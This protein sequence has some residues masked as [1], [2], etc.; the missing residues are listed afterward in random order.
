MRLFVQFFYGEVKK[1]F[2]GLATG[3][4]PDFIGFEQVFLR[5][6]ED[7][8]NPLQLLTHFN[9]LKRD[10]AEAVQ[11]FSTRFMKVCNSIPDQVKPPLGATQLHYVD[12]FS[13]DFALLLR[14]TRYATSADMMNDVIE[15]ELNLMA[16]RKIKNKVET[17]KK[18][19]KEENHPSSS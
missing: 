18:K 15:V 5:K 3:T 17:E 7:K 14:E 1:W 10:Y 12:A 16:Y 8:K 2:K 6:W 4:I 19:V 13:S 11:E 9:S